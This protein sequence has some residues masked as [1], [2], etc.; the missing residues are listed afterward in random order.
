MK[1]FNSEKDFP[2]ANADY[3][4]LNEGTMPDLGV[5]QKLLVKIDG[6][7]NVYYVIEDQ[8]ELTAIQERIPGDVNY[9]V[10]GSKELD[11][12]NPRDLPLAQFQEFIA[13]P[14][15]DEDDTEVE[16]QLQ[17]GSNGCLS[18][19]W[20]GVKAFAGSLEALPTALGPS[21]VAITLAKTDALGEVSDATK[22]GAAGLYLVCSTVGLW[23]KYGFVGSQHTKGSEVQGAP[24]DAESRNKTNYLYVFGL[25]LWTATEV[26]DAVVAAT[27]TYNSTMM[28]IGASLLLGGGKGLKTLTFDA[29]IVWDYLM[30]QDPTLL[31][32]SEH[33]L[34]GHYYKHQRGIAAALREIYGPLIGGIHCK[35]LYLLAELFRETFPGM[36]KLGVDVCLGIAAGV[37]M[38][39]VYSYG[40]VLTTGYDMSKGLEFLNSSLPEEQRLAKTPALTRLNLSKLSPEANIFLSKLA[41]LGHGFT[42]TEKFPAKL[43]AKMMVG[44]NGVFGQGA[45]YAQTGYEAIGQE[46]ITRINHNADLQGSP[47]LLTITVVAG[48]VAISITS[49]KTKPLITGGDLRKLFEEFE[50]HDQTLR[51]GA[52][53]YSQADS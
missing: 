2:N 37:V 41:R 22:L 47:A 50:T 3:P 25:C 21:I 28:K 35:K 53:G 44:T 14:V 23:F 8:A 16:Q 20:R 18:R 42:V 51:V 30:R 24:V 6:S 34:I 1:T 36:K 7:P 29:Q 13:V 15:R 33:A 26:C 43:L 31:P 19:F 4:S 46:A 40:A 17:N 49:G 32:L 52:L 48:A 45:L 5:D 10:V 9:C 11:E 27:T 38:P 12:F 39:F